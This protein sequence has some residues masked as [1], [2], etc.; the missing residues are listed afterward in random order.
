MTTVL[1]LYRGATVGEAKLISVSAD[2]DLVAYVAV[3]MLNDG[4]D[5]PRESADAVLGAV[6]AGRQRAL[7]LIAGNA[8]TGETRNRDGGDGA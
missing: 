5:E 4:A 1:A 8:R 2:S 7:R 6:A 3:R